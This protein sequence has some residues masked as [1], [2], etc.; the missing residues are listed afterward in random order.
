MSRSRKI[1]LVAAARC[2]NTGMKWNEERNSIGDRWGGPPLLIEP[3]EGEVRLVRE[4]EAPA[5]RVQP[6]DGC[7]RRKSP[8]T[9][10]TVKPGQTN[11]IPLAAADGTVWWVLESVGP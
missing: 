4:A 9:A 10:V 5:L 2:G 6:L 11:T 8:A 3:V 1:L 7:G